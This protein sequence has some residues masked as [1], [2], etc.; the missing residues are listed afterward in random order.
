[1]PQAGFFAPASIS[2]ANVY[3]L[4]KPKERKERKKW[5]VTERT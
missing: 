1:M 2:T 3:D 4:E 5:V